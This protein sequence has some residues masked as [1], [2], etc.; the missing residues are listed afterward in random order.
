FCAFGPDNRDCRRPGD[1]WRDAHDWREYPAARAGADAHRPWREPLEECSGR[2][3][4]ALA[5]GAADA[6]WVVGARSWRLCPRALPRLGEFAPD[7]ILRRAD[8]AIRG[9][10]E[11]RAESRV[12]DPGVHDPRRSL[13]RRV[14]GTRPSRRKAMAPRHPRIGTVEQAVGR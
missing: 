8:A 5:R 11:C 1:V 4:R 9:L 7:D 2:R 14:I 10:A 13:R 6:P 3:S 12:L